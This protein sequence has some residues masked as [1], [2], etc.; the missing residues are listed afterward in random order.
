MSFGW[1]VGDIISACLVVNEVIRALDGSRGSATKYQGLVNELH[2][3]NR[4]LLETE[5]LSQRLESAPELNALAATTNKIARDCVKTLEGF[6]EKLKK[7]E[8]S[9]LVGSDPSKAKMSRGLI[10][11]IRFLV[12][13]REEVAKV[14]AE[15]AG[16]C[17]SINL[18]LATASL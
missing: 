2:N 16:H 8:N 5:I 11:R 7:L 6:L 14:R 12:S 9:R 3:L 18:L 10:E 13:S 1:S 15:V 4:A 17:E